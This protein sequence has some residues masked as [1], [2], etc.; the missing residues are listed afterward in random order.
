[1]SQASE[2]VAFSNQ[3]QKR[4]DPIKITNNA[5]KQK[6]KKEDA[7][8]FGKNAPIKEVPEEHAESDK[9]VVKR[10]GPLKRK[11]TRDREIEN[12]YRDE[13]TMKIESN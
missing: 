5:T 2:Q 3:L 10:G 4:G 7:Y 1:M 9:P 8:N 11:S 6:N 13:L 12:E